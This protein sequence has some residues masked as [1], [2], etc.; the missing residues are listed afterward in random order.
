MTANVSMMKKE[1]WSRKTGLRQESCAMFVSGW[2]VV[3]AVAVAAVVV[4]VTVV[5][6]VVAVT[7]AA[8]ARAVC[9]WEGGGGGGGS[10]TGV[11]N[12][13][14][15]PPRAVT[16]RTVSISYVV[17]ISPTAQVIQQRRCVH[18]DVYNTT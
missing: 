18:G 2:R 8:A 6:V 12:S 13:P 5:V 3:V 11:H 10:E 17:L 15:C 1:E 9:V 16:I 14:S 4:V 7:L